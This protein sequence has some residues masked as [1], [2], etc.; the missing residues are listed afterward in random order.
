MRR[1]SATR[2]THP[3]LGTCAVAVVVALAACQETVA[4]QVVNADGQWQ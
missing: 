4:F 2:P 1:G 3:W